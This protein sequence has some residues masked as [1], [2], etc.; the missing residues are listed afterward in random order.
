MR[1]YTNE[2]LEAK[3]KRR[4][5]VSLAGFLKASAANRVGQLYLAP[6]LIAGALARAKTLNLHNPLIFFHHARR[7]T[8]NLHEASGSLLAQDYHWF[9]PLECPNKAIEQSVI[10]KL[11]GDLR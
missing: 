1:W 5:I 10:R 7:S 3:Q 2:H 9:V 6:G 4:T 11:K 8:L